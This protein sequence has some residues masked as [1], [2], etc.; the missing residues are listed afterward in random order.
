MWEVFRRI[1]DKTKCW[2]QWHGTNLYSLSPIV[3]LNY[4]GVSK[5]EKGG[6]ELALGRGNYTSHFWNEAAHFAT[7]HLIQKEEGRGVGL[8]LMEAQD[9]GKRSE[10]IKSCNEILVRVQLLVMV[11]GDGST[12]GPAIFHK[13]ENNGW[14]FEG[15]ATTEQQFPL[16]QLTS[17]P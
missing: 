14:A 13:L 8:N 17:L 10:I 11:P 15:T 16:Y 2:L 4:L 6:N 12:G 5:S 7:P 1:E 3:A 9:P